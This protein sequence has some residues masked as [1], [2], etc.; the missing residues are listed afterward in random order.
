M[1]LFPIGLLLLLGLGCIAAK[2]RT[3][4]IAIREILWDYAPSE[5]NIISGNTIADDEH[6]STFLLRDTNRIG[7]I[8]KKAVYQQYTDDSYT[9][10]VKKPDWLGFLGPIIKAE[11]GDTLIV[12]LKNFASRTYSLH[13]HGVQYTKENEGA[14]YPDNN[15]DS[16]KKSAAV[17]PGESFTYTWEAVTDQGPTAENEACVTR[18]YHSHVDGPMD[19]YSGLVGP[20]LVC[21]TGQMKEA[22]EKDFDE[23]ILMFSVIDENLSWYL[24]ENIKT[25]C[26]D[27]DSVDKEDEDFKESNKMHCINGYMF[28][29]LPGLSMCN[30]KQV[31]WYLFGMG[32][33]IDIH[34][35][36]FHGQVLTQQRYRVDT[37]SLFP[38]TMVQGEMLTNN[39]GKWLLSCQVNDHL[40]GG[41]QAIYEVRNCTKPK[42]KLMGKVRH[43]YIAAEEVI[44][45]YGPT[46]KNQFTGQNLDDPESE[47]A[48]FFEQNEARIGGSYKKVLYVGYTDATFTKRK[49]RSAEEEHLGL[50]GPIL[51]AQVQDIVKVTFRNNASR[52]YS[53]QAHGVSY[54]KNME[55]ASYRTSNIPEENKSPTPASH[56]EPGDTF[57]YDWYIPASFG[58]TPRDRNCLPWLYFSSV[59]PIKDTNTGLVGPLLV[60]QALKNDKQVGIDHLYFLL[61]AVFDENE[62]WLLDENIHLFTSSPDKV[63]KEDPDFKES[64]MMHSIN[65]Y[66]YGNQP[67]LEM[68]T[69]N[70]VLWYVMGIGSEVDMHGI[71][72]TGNT[73]TDHHS[74]RRDVASVFPHIS[75]SASMRPDNAGLFDV[76][77]MTTDHF[78]GGMKQHY[79]VKDCSSQKKSKIV[80]PSRQTYYI[81]AEEVEWDYSPNRTWEHERHQHHDES[82]G[83]VFLK[84]SD[85]FIGS[86]YKKAVY[87]EYTDKTFTTPKARTQE[88][89]HLEIL[90]PLIKANVGSQVKIIFHNKASRPY[91]IYAHGVKTEGDSVQPA[92]PG[93]TRTYIWDIPERSGPSR[94]HDA[95]CVTWA[96]YSNVNQIKDTY[97]GLIGPVVICK[98]SLLP[99]KL[100]MPKIKRF[101]LLFMVY[102]ENESW[103]LDENI[104]MY[105]KFP[106][107]VNKEDE[108]FIESNKMHAINGKMYA[109]LLGL[110]MRVGDHVNWHLIGMGGEVDLHTVHFHAHSFN[111]QKDGT[112]RSDVFDLFPGTF[113]TVEMVAKV[114]GTWLLHCHVADHIHAGMETLYTVLEKDTFRL[115]VK[116]A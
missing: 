97:S 4:Y 53:I 11:V 10:E 96:Y 50:L 45:N 7:R 30:N 98:S 28:G 69:G 5:R 81:A 63:N 36:Y 59:D 92:E 33:E 9:V 18:V 85:T 115:N 56:V 14:S 27:P 100:F 110:T 51:L 88:Q 113:Q 114:P 3:Y 109:N 84:K 2:K 57:T 61:S 17:K 99:I 82:P 55:G 107:K 83:E 60:C 72:F 24:D 90:G 74:G 23:F 73:F 89:E 62:S 37:I 35:A 70:S 86:K 95:N 76:K 54:T 46:L 111:F 48:P 94:N 68:C 79:R 112:F 34:A 80:I 42:C 41:M 6:A 8:Y 71:H 25:F 78:T 16:L 26:T 105:S 93:Q 43:Y 31:K 38:A 102:D 52:P 20:M 22:D 75:I 91:S 108:D 87:R 67:G 77:C 15:P 103:Y 40:E 104:K 44:W 66:M 13:P 101:A 47:S 39:I 12:N 19:V 65:G 106:D 58:S 64:N 32:N 116:K 49:E 29:N 21:K 1:K